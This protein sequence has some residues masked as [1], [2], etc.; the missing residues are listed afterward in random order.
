M[1]KKIG[2]FFSP[3]SFLLPFLPYVAVVGFVLG[4]IWY[5]D[6]KGYQRAQKDAE[7]ERMVTAILIDK[8][9][10]DLETNLRDTISGIDR[11]LADRIANIDLINRTI[12]QPTIEKEIRNDPRFSDP[13]LGITSVM[14]DALN[15]AIKQSTCPAAANGGDCVSL[16]APSVSE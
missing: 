1:L 8:Y 14:R 15:R 10:S 2:G 7:F 4:G 11:N 13:N 6:H 16:P 3:L 5:I 12:I 9:V